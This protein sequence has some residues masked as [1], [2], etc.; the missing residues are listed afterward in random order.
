MAEW[1]QLKG[2]PAHLLNVLTNFHC[3]ICMWTLTQKVAINPALS[4]AF[5]TKGAKFYYIVFHFL[6]KCSISMALLHSSVL[7]IIET[8]SVYVWAF[9]CCSKHLPIDIL[10][11]VW[12]I[13]HIQHRLHVSFRAAHVD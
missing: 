10:V 3:P 4:S 9:P 2:L 8:E 12:F 13:T 6:A 7:T 11:V 5:V 1:S